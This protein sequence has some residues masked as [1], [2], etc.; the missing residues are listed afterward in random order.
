[1]DV[2]AT[3]IVPNRLIERLDNAAALGSEASNNAVA[4]ADELPPKVTPRVT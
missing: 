1:M 2:N 4:I 3:K